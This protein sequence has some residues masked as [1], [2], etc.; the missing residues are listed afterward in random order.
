MPKRPHLPW[1]LLL[2][3]CS[4]GCIPDVVPNEA[5]LPNCY[6]VAPTCGAA[7]NVSCCN[8]KE[9]QGG[10]FTLTD[11]QMSG[12]SA[13]LVNSFLLD[14]FEVTVGR[15]RQ[16][17]ADYPNSAP[18]P[19]DGAHPLIPGSGWNPAWD[20]GQLPTDATA[21]VANITCPQSIPTWTDTPGPNESLPINCINWQTAFAFCAWD[22][23]RLP[24]DAEWSYA[25]SGGIDQRS[26]PWGSDPPDPNHAVY[27]TDYVSNGCVDAALTDI[28]PVG[29]KLAGDGLYG[30]ADLAGSMGEWTLDWFNAFPPACANCANLDNPEQR[31]LR[32]TWGGDWAHDATGLHAFSRIGRP[33]DTSGQSLDF[34]GVRCARD[35]MPPDRSVVP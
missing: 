16:F 10:M 14:G 17:V 26:Y 8:A 1:L 25:A 33:A 27:C 21:L 20:F 22:G 34:V 30:Q 3:L 2:G 23:G 35:V 24:T 12:S 9:V 32:S 5:S 15:F 19:G 28:L 4:S 11:D 18:A 6:G 31:N 7:S 13:A 29:S